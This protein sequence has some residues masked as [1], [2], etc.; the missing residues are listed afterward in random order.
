MPGGEAACSV[1]EGTPLEQ[2]Q[3]FLPRDLVVF[4]QI[5]EGPLGEMAPAQ[6]SGVER[7]RMD[8]LPCCSLDVARAGQQPP[9]GPHFPVVP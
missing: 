9:R 6:L 7:L 8:L 4:E 3:A 2:S 1:S 5:V